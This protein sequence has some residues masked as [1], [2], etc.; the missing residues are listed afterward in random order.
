MSRS[1]DNSIGHATLKVRILS[2]QRMRTC[3]IIGRLLCG[4]QING[5]IQRLEHDD[6]ELAQCLAATE[7]MRRKEV[8][9][10]CL[11]GMDADKAEALRRDLLAVD[12]RGLDPDRVATVADLDG[13]LGEVEWDWR[14]WLPRGFL[15]ILAAQ[16]G[17]GKS[18]VALWG[19]CRSMLCGSS[20][21]DGKLPEAPVD[22]RVLWVEAESAHQLLR[23]RVKAAG[24]PAKRI[25]FPTWNPLESL[26][27][28]D[29]MAV[30]DLRDTVKIHRPRLVVVDALSGTHSKRENANDEMLP[31]I[32]PLA[33]LARDF[34]IP[35]LLIHHVSKQQEGAEINLRS[36]RGATAITQ[37]S[38]CVW[39]LDRPDESGW[40][41]LRCIKNNLAP[42]P[43][44]IGIRIGHGC[45]EYGA[46]PRP[47]RAD[48]KLAKAEEF[49]REKLQKGPRP[50]SEL[51]TE[52]AERDITRPTLY[53]AKDSMGLTTVDGC[54]ALPANEDGFPT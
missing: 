46:A 13:V 5:E 34:Q 6:L 21:P 23:E 38:R 30:M 10:E 51:I 28:D 37:L 43:E 3:W 25:I 53:R 32:R 35:V 52:A 1:N 31:V 44:P 36:I 39:A 24:L 11:K 42:I 9:T 16:Q 40:L 4:E 33:D 7:M 47:P 49:L 2:R 20:W 50:P 17:D 41:R 15:S 48:T 14:G 22:C 45:L 54:W 29:A 12:P 27:L 19:V 26:Q 18:L 8:F